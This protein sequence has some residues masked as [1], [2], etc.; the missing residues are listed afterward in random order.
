MA[1]SIVE[2][3]IVMVPLCFPNLLT[4]FFVVVLWWLLGQNT[5][6]VDGPK[7]HQNAYIRFWINIELLDF[8]I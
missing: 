2:T 8:Q 6:Q 7:L 1:S 5:S 4:S 3:D